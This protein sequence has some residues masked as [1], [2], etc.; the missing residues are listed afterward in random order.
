MQ[1]ISRDE[2]ERLK[3]AAADKMREMG[4]RQTKTVFPSFVR[5][6]TGQDREAPQEEPLVKTEKIKSAGRAN[7][8]LKYMNLPE[9]L[10][11]KDSLLILGLILLLSNEEADET[12]IMALAYI[13]L[14]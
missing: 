10:K 6:P 12:L 2:F 3:N 8:F 1:D 4:N 11:D 13:L 5:V 7:N 9:L 14:P